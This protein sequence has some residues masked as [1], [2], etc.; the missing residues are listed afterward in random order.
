MTLK[1]V[2]FGMPFITLAFMSMLAFGIAR[3]NRRSK[4]RE[5]LEGGAFIIKG[6]KVS[7]RFQGETIPRP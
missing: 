4:Q 7:W 5:E 2:A 3:H 6:S 1:L